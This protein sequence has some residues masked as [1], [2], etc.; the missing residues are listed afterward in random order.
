MNK[1][2]SFGQLE[3]DNILD[4][5]PSEEKKKTERSPAARV[6]QSAKKAKNK[7][8]LDGTKCCLLHLART[9]RKHTFNNN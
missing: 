1:T 9:P 5:N 2:T 4:Y 8:C 6:N 7:I 3:I